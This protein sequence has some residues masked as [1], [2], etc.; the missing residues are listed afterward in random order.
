LTEI[1]T[2]VQLGV[3]VALAGYL[4]SNPRRVVLVA[5]VTIASG[6]LVALVALAEQAGLVSLGTEI[7]YGDGYT[8]VSGLLEDPNYFSFQLL[9]ALSF[10]VHVA[11]AARSTLARVLTW[12]AFGI[13]V[14][15]IVS[16]YSAGALVGMAVLVGTALVLQFKVSTKRAGAIFLVMAAV[17]VAV[18]LTAPAQYGEAVKEKFG[19]LAGSS[20]EE[21]GTKRG[22]AWEAGAR[23]FLHNPVL[24]TGFSS[25]NEEAAIAEFYTLYSTGRKAAH[26]MYIAVAVTTGLFGLAAFLVAFASALWLVWSTHSKAVQARDPQA[27]LAAA[28]VFTALAVIAIQGLQLDIQFV[29]YT[30]L[31]LGAALGIQRWRLARGGKGA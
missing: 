10:A 26:N 16:S 20:F 4:L 17:A 6:V 18:A 30:W 12:L 21:L 1:L 22:A 5:Y 11:S 31:M 2:I 8:R 25:Q 24:G 15:G 9:I 14:A 29:K 19:S 3:L 7:T 28:C 23:E 27:E 13:I